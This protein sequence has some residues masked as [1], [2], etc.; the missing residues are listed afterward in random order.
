MTRFARGV[1]PTSPTTGRSPRPMMNSTAVRTLPYQRPGSPSQAARSAAP[2]AWPPCSKRFVESS[3]LDADRKRN[4]PP[5]GGPNVMRDGLGSG[6]CVGLRLLLRVLGG[7][8]RFL[9]YDCGLL[10][11]G[12]HIVGRGCRLGFA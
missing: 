10:V 7:G 3:A 11:G 12:S 8:L 9:G 1:R 6:V 4:G 5:V 2:G